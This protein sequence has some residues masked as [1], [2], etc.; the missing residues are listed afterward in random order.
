MKIHDQIFNNV[1]VGL[2]NLARIFKLSYFEI[3]I[4]VYYFLVP[5]SWMALLDGIFDVHYF[6]VAFLFFCLG[7]GTMVRDFYSFS[8]VLY[9][10][11]VIFLN[12]FNRYNSNY[13]LSSVWICVVIPASIY[14]ILISLFCN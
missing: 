14:V 7:L 3:N 6:K 11:S 9:K 12:Y 1:A 13:V 10:K 2:L 5:L 8:I 4:I